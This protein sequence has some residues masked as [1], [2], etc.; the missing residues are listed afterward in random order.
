[1]KVGLLTQGKPGAAGRQASRGVST[2]C[3]V[4]VTVWLATGDHGEPCWNKE[5]PMHPGIPEQGPTRSACVDKA[6]R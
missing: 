4:D 2:L 5:R 3:R 1:M 6:Y